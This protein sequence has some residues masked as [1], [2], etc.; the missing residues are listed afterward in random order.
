MIKAF[1]DCVGVTGCDGCL[2]TNQASNAGLDGIV[3]SLERDRNDNFRVSTTIPLSYYNYY[4]LYGPITF[5]L[6]I[7]ITCYRPY[8]MPTSGKSRGSL[9]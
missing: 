4:N 3:R 8:H 6:N 7:N 1:H 9:L 2:N 5:K